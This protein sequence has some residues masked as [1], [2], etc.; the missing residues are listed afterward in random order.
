MVNLNTASQTTPRLAVAERWGSMEIERQ[1][2]RSLFYSA[3]FS[4]NVMLQGIG[5]NVAASITRGYFGEF[6]GG[7]P[8]L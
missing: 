6:A 2:W 1:R 7:M 5:H 4:R 8:V 3:M